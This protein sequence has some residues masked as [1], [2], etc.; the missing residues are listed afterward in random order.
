MNPVIPDTR[1][2]CKL[3]L[4]T[5]LEQRLNPFGVTSES[6]NQKPPMTAEEI[7]KEAEERLNALPSYLKKKQTEEAKNS[8]KSEII[9]FE[10]MVQIKTK[11]KM[12]EIDLNLERLKDRDYLRLIK[13]T[14]RT[15]QRSQ[16]IRMPKNVIFSFRL[17]IFNTK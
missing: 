11:F 5:P 9:P 7:K 14:T 15:K 2:N 16:A 8:K 3:G 1:Y 4:G 17:K 13:V 10:D 6:S 12:R